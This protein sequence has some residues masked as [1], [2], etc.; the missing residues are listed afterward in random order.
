MRTVMRGLGL[1][2]AGSLC[3]SGGVVAGEART[4]VEFDPALGE[5]P[6]GVTATD[7]GTVY[8]GLS[9]TGRI[10][11]IGRD[12]G[13]AELVT[14]D[15]DADD[16]GP[17]GM[18]L[19]EF[20]TLLSTVIGADPSQHGVILVDRGVEDPETRGMW[21]HVEGTEGLAMPNAIALDPDHDLYLT[22]SAAGSV[23][24]SEWRAFM[25]WAAAE[26]WVSDAS[27]QGTGALPFPFPVGAN[28]IAIGDD[29]V[30]VGVTEQSHIVGIPI[31]SDGMAGEP[32]VHLD[33][34]GVAIDGIAI[35]DDGEFVI[36]DPPANTIWIVGEDGVPTVLAGE[37][38]GISGPTSVA[39]GS[40]PDGE[41][42]YV[43][44]MAQA[45]VGD[46]AKHPPSIVA[47]ELD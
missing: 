42:V 20:G 11:E 1:A 16:F 12:G 35:T 41:T 40:G 38:E 15:L 46:L 44:N 24:R 8:A 10:V 36:A 21:W 2:V 45:V 34:D 30:Y 43:A 5:F 23:W 25:G 18:A 47:I 17:A 13:V 31:E 19:A 33:L 29:T 4:L 32:F 39:I 14:I 27:L 3:L 6:E 9:G 22:D 37:T 26:P 28:G 7:E